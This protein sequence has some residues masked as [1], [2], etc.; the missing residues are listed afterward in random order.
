MPLTEAQEEDFAVY[1]RRPQTWLEGS[2]RHLAVFEVLSDRLDVPR[3]QSGASQDE[4]SGCYYAAYLHAG[5]AVENAVKASLIARDP[6]IIERGRI[7]RK[8]LGDRSGHAFIAATEAILGS[9]SETER[10]ILFKL[11]E[12]VVWA[13]KYTVPMDGAVLY[14]AESM[15]KLR[16]AP[17]NERAIVLS[18]VTRLH[19]SISAA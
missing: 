2:R 10:S 7:A 14:D 6:S 15:Q 1:A 11:E 9:L 13:G 5:L 17:M 16:T 12:F 4:R 8:K 18:L 19:S 3:M